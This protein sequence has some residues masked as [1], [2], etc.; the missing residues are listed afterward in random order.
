[1]PQFQKTDWKNKPST[2]TPINATNLNRIEDC[3]ADLSGIGILNFD[4]LTGGG[5]GVIYRVG[6]LCQ[7]VLTFINPMALG[8]QSELFS[9]PAEFK[10]VMDFYTQALGDNYGDTLG[11]VYY[12]HA[13]NM[14]SLRTSATDTFIAK[15]SF[16]YICD[17]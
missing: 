3:L 13:S 6:N 12:N 7:L 5:S 1:M 11:L 15:V 2:E 9:F 10:P 16:T 8:G 4:V 17:V 14:M